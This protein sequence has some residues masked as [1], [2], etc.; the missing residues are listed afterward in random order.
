MADMVQ[1]LQVSVAAGSLSATITAGVHYVAPTAGYGFARIVGSGQAGDGIDNAEFGGQSQRNC[2][3][4]TNP[5]NIATSLNLA[6]TNSNSD[7]KIQVEI[8]DFSSLAGTPNEIVVRGV[9]TV[10]YAQTSETVDSTQV[11]GVVDDADVVALITGAQVALSFFDRQ[12]AEQ[13]RSSC[14]WI[15]GATDVVRCTR[16]AGGDTANTVTS[17]SL[18][19]LEFTGSAWTVQRITHTFVAADTDE[20]EAMSSVGNIANAAILQAQTEINGTETGAAAAGV[21]AWISSATQVTFRAEALGLGKTAVAWVISN[22]NMNVQH[23]SG[24]RLNDVGTNPDTWT[25]TISAVVMATASVV[26]EGATTN[27][28]VDVN[29]YL[30]GF[31]LTAVDTVTLSRGSNHE[32]RDY[33]FS[34]VSWPSIAV[35]AT[36]SLFRHA[37]P[38]LD[39]SAVQIG[40]GTVTTRYLRFDAGSYTTPFYVR[41]DTIVA[42]QQRI[43]A[44]PAR[45]VLKCGSIEIRSTP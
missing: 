35:G 10:T 42:R 43:D 32:R 29:H 45:L 38:I 24:S 2:F 15:G 21:R 27:V 44:L 5:S 12:A 28:A 1:R 36:G 8:Y 19:V 18:A 30:M 4:I 20:T 22:A 13:Y 33:R 40:D 3:M 16:G 7:V 25:E 23:I 34:I 14:Q 9:R 37:D 17:L 26:G 6:R 31:R 39:G 41:P 11:T